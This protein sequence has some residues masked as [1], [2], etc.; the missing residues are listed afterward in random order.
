MYPRVLHCIRPSS[1][2]GETECS[3]HGLATPPAPYRH[4]ICTAHPIRLRSARSKH[5][6]IFW[7]QSIDCK[8][9]FWSKL[10][11]CLLFM[12]WKNKVHGAYKIFSHNNGKNY[13]IMAWIQCDMC[14]PLF[15]FGDGAATAAALGSLPVA[16]DECECVR[17]RTWIAFRCSV[18][19]RLFDRIFYRQTAIWNGTSKF[20][21]NKNN[22]DAKRGSSLVFAVLRLCAFLFPLCEIRKKKPNRNR[23]ADTLPFVSIC[24][25]KCDRFHT[26][27]SA[28]TRYKYGVLLCCFMHFSYAIYDYDV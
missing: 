28:S 2:L 20:F 27:F 17:A 5:N 6:I 14:Y 4:S 24:A 3:S 13:F 1:P 8:I 26:G 10:W 11:P 23:H 12:N 9:I 21:D 25:G 22:L 15:H 19:E 7:Q 18:I 16:V